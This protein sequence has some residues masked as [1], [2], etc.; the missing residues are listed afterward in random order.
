MTK[1]EIERKIRAA[2]RAGRV[3]ICPSDGVES[4]PRWWVENFLSDVLG[5]YGAW[6]SDESSLSDF[7]EKAR[8]AR[9][10]I[11]EE[12]GADVGSETNLLAIFRMIHATNVTL[13]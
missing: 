2:A 12:Y 7:G 13:Q 6:I 8:G 4:F 3:S 5:V 9:N 10:H 1:K 11:I